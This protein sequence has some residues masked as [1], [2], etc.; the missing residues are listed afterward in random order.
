[1]DSS[2]CNRLKD[3]FLAFAGAFPVGEVNLF[4]TRYDTN[5]TPL[6]IKQLFC[7]GKLSIIS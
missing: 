5:V 4:Q 7:T 2:T 6:P 3:I 1:M